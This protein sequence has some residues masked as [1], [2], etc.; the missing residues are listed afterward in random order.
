MALPF[1]YAD[2]HG[3]LN[4]KDAPYLLTD[5]QSRDLQN[6]QGTTAGAIVKRTGLTTLATP[7][8]TLT[9]L[10]PS[11]ATSPNVLVGAGGTNLYS[12]T[13]GGVVT[14][15]KSSLTNNARWEWVSAPATG[16]QGP[17]YGI[18]GTDNPQQWTGSGSTADWTPS[19][20]GYDGWGGITGTG[21]P[22]GKYMAYTQNQIFIAGLT[23]YPHRVCWCAIGQPRIWHSLD[24][25]VPPAPTGANFAEFDPNDG[26]P[27]TGLGVI[28]PYVLVFKRRKAWVIVS[29][30]S[31]TAAGAISQT[32]TLRQLSSNVGC[33]SHRS[34]AAG[35]NGTYFLAEDNGVY[36]TNG[37]KLTEMS[38]QIQ[39]TIDSITDRTRTAGV[40]FDG[41]YYLS[42]PILSASND[43]VLDYDEALQS[44]WKHD[45]G[46]NQ[47]AI[48]HPTGTARLY[49]AK[50]TSAVVD[51]CFTPN[52]YTDNGNAFTW[53]WRG[54]WQSPSYARRRRFPTPYY[55]KRLRQLRYDGSG[56]VDF[57]IAK[58]FIGSE[59]LQHQN[60]FNYDPSADLFA[61]S[62]TFAGTGFFAGQAGVV[63]ARA[64]TLGV[65]NSFSI[66][67][68]G[69][70]S[71][72]A[73]VNSYTML[74][75]DR[76]DLVVA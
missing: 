47:F 19:D 75:T 17:V 32:P 2:F 21:V 14:S 76:K 26:Q 6:V 22:N 18:D 23:D 52:T 30:T 24:T 15:I 71:S 63:E 33:V 56:Y 16:G 55:R 73:T 31:T 34:I 39:P 29:T 48:W 46:S 66:V 58:D 43:T 67:F 5:D 50:G 54:P 40:W 28:G 7:A 38:A 51:R 59:V 69:S 35:P 64:Y 12:I 20:A 61:G 72:P 9:S 11:E 8:V 27:I 44:W 60:I 13:S 65:A 62:G 74:L 3:G 1:I 25:S 10:F 49:S 53:F 57:Y 42:A 4:T 36:L 68:T 41:H 70:S 45:F 37:S